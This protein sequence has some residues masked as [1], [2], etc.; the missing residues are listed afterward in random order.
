MD[1]IGWDPSVL[2][3]IIIEYTYF[4]HIEDLSTTRLKSVHSCAALFVVL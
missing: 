3:P 1:W 4:A 2:S